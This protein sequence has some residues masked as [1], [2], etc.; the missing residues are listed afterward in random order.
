[1]PRFKAQP[2]KLE[3]ERAILVG[4]DT[5]TGEWSL[6]ESL[7]ELGRLVET[8]GGEVV[9]TLAQ[10]LEVP[11]ARTYL[12]RLRSSGILRALSTRMSWYS[13]TS[14]LRHSSQISRR[15]SAPM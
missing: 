14:S 5:G 4:V 12:A 2:T 7:A 3:P 10:R 11:V 13:T 15:L 9:A 1:M 6:D 8:D